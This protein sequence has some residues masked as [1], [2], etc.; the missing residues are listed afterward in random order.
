MSTPEMNAEL[1]EQI[2][3]NPWL[4]PREKR[5][6]ELKYREGLLNYQIAQKIHCSK[7]TVGRDLRRV[8]KKT[9]PIIIKYYES[10]IESL[11]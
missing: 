11:P 5:V 9:E 3:S 8:L 7:E 6:F 2:Y 10:F 4:T 1:L